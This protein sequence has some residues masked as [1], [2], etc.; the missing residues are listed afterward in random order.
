MP[1]AVAGDA[2]ARPTPEARGGVVYD[3]HC[4]RCHGAALQGQ[5]DWRIRNPDGKLPAPPHDDTGHTWHHPDR[6]L[7]EI[8]KFGLV[9]PHAPPGYT[10]DMPAFK[11]KLSDDD[12]HAVLR[13]IKSAWSDDIKAHQA[14]INT[15][16]VHAR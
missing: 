2:A 10:S 6:V 4:A 3:T 7:F 11:D 5:P 9:P 8:V 14:D 1:A 15:R 13:Y 16:A 12:I